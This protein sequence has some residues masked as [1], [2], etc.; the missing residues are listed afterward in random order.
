MW[1]EKIALYSLFQRG[2]A[3]AHARFDAQYIAKTRRKFQHLKKNSDDY[4]TSINT[5]PKQL[6]VDVS[7]ISQNDAQTGIQRVVRAIVQQLLCHPAPEGFVVRTVAATRKSPYRIVEWP[8]EKPSMQ[9]EITTGNC[10]A[11]EIEIRPGDIFLGLDLCT[12][13]IPAHQKQLAKWQRRGAKLNFV[14]Y[15]LL[16]LINPKWF[17]EKTVRYF[18]RWLTSLVVLADQIICISSEGAKEFG[19]YTTS[20]YQLPIDWVPVRTLPMGHDIAASQPSTGL[21]IDFEQTLTRIQDQ[22]SILMVGTLEPRKG[23]EQVLKAFEH[24]WSIG[25]NYTL[26][27]VGRPGWK[28]GSLQAWLKTHPELND[29]LIWLDDASDQALDLIYRNC[30]GVLIASQGEGFGLPLVEA[31]GYGRPVLVRDIPVFRE[32]NHPNITYFA[33]SNAIELAYCIQNWLEQHDSINHTRR[34]YPAENHPTWAN[35]RTA[36]WATL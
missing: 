22:K 1:L 31:L 19:N 8:K 18:Q 17:P 35:C 13:I 28:T 26:V 36:L 5:E 9:T 25:K 16:P 30:I 11:K 20:N 2:L 7:I 14:V 4:K 29:R 15:D 24:L 21:P 32:Q 6:L 34:P 33:T 23:H 27:L 10:A 12:R 3:S